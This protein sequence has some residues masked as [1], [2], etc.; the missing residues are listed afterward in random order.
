MVISLCIAETICVGKEEGFEGGLVG[1]YTEVKASLHRL[2]ITH[3]KQHP[4][5]YIFPLFTM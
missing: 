2:I 5:L 3:S 1:L 4:L